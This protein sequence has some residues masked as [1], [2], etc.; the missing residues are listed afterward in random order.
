MS[1]SSPFIIREGRT[2]QTQGV[3]FERLDEM[4]EDFAM[5]R[6]LLLPSSVTW[7]LHYPL[8]EMPLFYPQQ[9]RADTT[10]GP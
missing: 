3:N 1:S 9:S 6:A 4:S 2:A 10:R 8:D 7:P 5:Y